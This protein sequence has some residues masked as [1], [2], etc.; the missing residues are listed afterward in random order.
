MVGD[1]S[2][3]DPVGSDGGPGIMGPPKS[4]PLFATCH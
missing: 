4:P 2:P 1:H 3:G